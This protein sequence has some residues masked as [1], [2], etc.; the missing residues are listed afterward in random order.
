MEKPSATFP[1]VKALV[2]I[3]TLLNQLLL[4]QTTGEP[5]P[6]SRLPLLKSESFTEMPDIRSPCN[7]QFFQQDLCFI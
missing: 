1:D 2:A 3:I 6:V 5:T 4:N 7:G